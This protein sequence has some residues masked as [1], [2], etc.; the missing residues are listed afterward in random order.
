L[1]SCPS[2]GQRKGKRACPALGSEICSHCCGTKRRVQIACPSDCVWL[3]AHAGSWEGRETERLRDVR[4]LAPHLQGLT[5]PQARLFFLGLVGLGPLHA[6]HRELN[7]ALV[8]QAIAALRKTLETREK[9]ILYEHAAEDLRAQGLVPEVRG[10]FEVKDA[11]GATHPVEDRD[12][13]PVL[14][15]FES[16]LGDGAGLGPTAF[17]D[18]AH[19]IAG[20]MSPAPATPTS[21]LIVAP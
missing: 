17:L 1:A 10:M 6:R 15:A 5:D 3:G 7:D 13:L 21:P 11:A 14:R 12:L 20:Q 9:G 16:A 19:R 2:C 18:T 8:V 4:R